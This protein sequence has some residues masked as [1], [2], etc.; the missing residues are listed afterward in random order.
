M[1]IL[2]H[3]YDEYCNLSVGAEVKHE[4]NYNIES[5]PFLDGTDIFT[6]MQKL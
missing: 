2:D 5:I 3:S 6:P 1:D 4:M